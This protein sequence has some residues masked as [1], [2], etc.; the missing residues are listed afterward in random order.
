VRD[1]HAALSSLESQAFQ[2]RLSSP[3]VAA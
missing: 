3:L 2:A 1:S